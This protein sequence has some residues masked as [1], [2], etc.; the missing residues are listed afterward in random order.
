MNFII[1]KEER[2]R[3][4]KK[5]KKN[6]L[7]PSHTGEKHPRNGEVSA[8]LTSDACSCSRH[9][10]YPE[11]GNNKHQ[12][13]WDKEMITVIIVLQITNVQWFRKN[14]TNLYLYARKANLPH[15]S[16]SF[17]QYKLCS[18]DLQQ[19]SHDLHQI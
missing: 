12:S 6:L 4:G 11:W 3:T 18:L 19:E 7:C 2:K 15:P 17:I 5:K 14:K 10:L 8:P 16:S 13:C 9:C 1:F